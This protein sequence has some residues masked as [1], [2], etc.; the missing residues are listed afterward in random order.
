MAQCKGFTRDRLRAALDECADTEYRIKSGLI[1]QQ[2]G[3]EMLLVKYSRRVAV[4][5]R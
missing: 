3:L 5:N 2:I 4:A 1:D